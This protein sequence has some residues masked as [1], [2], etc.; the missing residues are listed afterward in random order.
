V[1]IIILSVLCTAF[2]F[3]TIGLVM[4]N[5]QL[6]RTLGAALLALRTL[7]DMMKAAIEAGEIGDKNAPIIVRKFDNMN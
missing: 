2:F 3:S 5:R 6:L 1:T 4:V 7:D